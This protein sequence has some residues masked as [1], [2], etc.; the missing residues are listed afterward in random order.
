MGW[1]FQFNITR[2][3]LISEYTKNE[4]SKDCN[5][6]VKDKNGELN[7]YFTRT[8]LKHCFRGNFF[9][10]VL[11]SVWEISVKDKNT[12]TLIESYRY[13][14]CDLIK[15]HKNDGWGIKNMDES[16]HPYYFSCPLSYLS[17]AGTPRTQREADWR[18]MVVE[19]HKGK[20]VLC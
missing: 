16:M 8:C 3:E 19:H 5:R 11:W 14:G 15:Y 1:L 2:K 13:I 20:K 18:K 6:F 4:N 17:L 9:I 7:H 10:G 12:D